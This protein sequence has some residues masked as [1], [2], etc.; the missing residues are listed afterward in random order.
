MRTIAERWLPRARIL[1]PWP[2]RRFDVRTETRAECVSSARSDP[3]GGRPE[4]KG[5]GRPY[6]DHGDALGNGS[7]TN[8][9]WPVPV[10]GLF[11]ATAVSVGNYSACA[12]LVGGSMECWGLNSDGQLGD[13]TTGLSFTP[14][15]VQ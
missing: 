12:L 9:A 3:C 14:V 4:P 1:H 7:A 6:R 5:K 10:S 13:G 8:T 15:M 2:E 11:G